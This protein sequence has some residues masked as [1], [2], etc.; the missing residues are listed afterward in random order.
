MKNSQLKVMA[1]MSVSLRCST[2]VD[3]TGL[4][5]ITASRLSR[6]ITTLL[7]MVNYV[8]Y[9]LC[10]KESYINALRHW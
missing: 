2:A 1:M 6:T 9:S 5:F 10:L 4:F 7:K 8:T 3:H